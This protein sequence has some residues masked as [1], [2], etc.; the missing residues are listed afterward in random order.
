MSAEQPNR[1][2]VPGNDEIEAKVNS[3]ETNENE[4]ESRI[5]RVERIKREKEMMPAQGM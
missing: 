4:M 3:R 1:H 2:T 5:E